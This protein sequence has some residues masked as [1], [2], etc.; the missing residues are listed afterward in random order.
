MHDFLNRAAQLLA[1][2]SSRKLKLLT[3]LYPNVLH[4]LLERVRIDRLPPHRVYVV[5]TVCVLFSIA[6]R[7]ARI[8]HTTTY[9]GTACARFF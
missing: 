4:T 9:Y 5:N 7:T 3:L 1:Q 8:L 2:G 6:T